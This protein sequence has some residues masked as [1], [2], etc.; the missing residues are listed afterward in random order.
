MSH[1]SGSV[2]GHDGTPLTIAHV[3]LTSPAD[4]ATSA[5]AVQ[6]GADHRYRLTTEATGV[7]ALTFSGVGHE[8]ER[9][10]LFLPRKGVRAEVDVTLAAP[11]YTADAAKAAVIG[12]FNGF[13]NDV[14]S[15]PMSPLPN[16][17]FIA[18]IP[19]SKGG[20]LAYQIVNVTEPVEEINST[21]PGPPIAAPGAARYVRRDDGRY[22]AVVGI[23]SGTATIEFD[24]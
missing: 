4:S 5:S 12:D 23:E 20:T 6:V 21:H 19:Y 13:R 7:V 2:R 8:P 9:V 10:L 1:I 14:S 22:A 3:E 18:Q 16:G 17:R 11:R 15:I 24:P